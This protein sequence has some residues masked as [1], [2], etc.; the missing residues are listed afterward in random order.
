[1]ILCNKFIEDYTVNIYFRTFEA[2]I[3]K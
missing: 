1:L 3:I 2:V